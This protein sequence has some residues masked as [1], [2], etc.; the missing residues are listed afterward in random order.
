MRNKIKI[1]LSRLYEPFKPFKPL[2]PLDPLEPFKPI[3]PKLLNR[4]LKLIKIN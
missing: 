4:T 2:I 3:K 1:Q